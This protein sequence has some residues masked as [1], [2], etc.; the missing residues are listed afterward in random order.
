MI[1]VAFK[2]LSYHLYDAKVTIK[3]DHTPLCK[4][5]TAY[6]LNFRINNWG[7]G[8]ASMSHV[9]FEHIKGAKTFYQTIF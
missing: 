3:Y 4:S 2:K 6:T 7:A 1:Y 5:F 8:T 9:K